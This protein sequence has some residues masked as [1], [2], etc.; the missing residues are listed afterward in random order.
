MTNILSTGLGILFFLSLLMLNEVSAAQSGSE[1]IGVSNAD[2]E[3]SPAVF[4]YGFG[5]GSFHF[6]A[7]DGITLLPGEVVS[8]SVCM[9]KMEFDFIDFSSVS[10]EVFGDGA[11]LWSNW[12][13]DTFSTC[14]IGR[15]TENLPI[16]SSGSIFFPIKVESSSS[17]NQP[18]WAQNNINVNL[19]PHAND[20]FGDPND[21]TF[22]STYTT[23]P[24]DDDYLVIS[25]EIAYG[26]YHAGIQISSDGVLNG[27]KRSKFYSGNEIL[28]ESG[29]EVKLNSEFIA[30][31]KPCE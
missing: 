10:D 11:S 13:Y 7:L 3:F 27:M 16:N 15:I 9:S 4:P 18:V 6:E 19:Q 2:I 24:C 23:S 14:L 12:S 17:I 21:N 30:D 1:D 26:S 5:L 20:A 31:I 29:F 22:I 25:D 8:V 28:L